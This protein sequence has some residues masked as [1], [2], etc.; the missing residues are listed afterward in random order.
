MKRYFVPNRLFV[1]LMAAAAVILFNPALALAQ[2]ATPGFFT[3]F[4]LEN[5]LGLVIS[6]LTPVV[7]WA[8]K[9]V[10][11]GTIPT[12]L[13]PLLAGT[14]VPWLIDFVAGLTAGSDLSMWQVSLYGLVG[15]ALREILDQL[16]KAPGKVK[17]AAIS[18]LLL[19]GMRPGA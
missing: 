14:V 4:P 19:I 11:W 15:V 9:K 6:V 5:V 3:D 1:F 16:K 17:A 18:F 10:P 8:I 7:V 12:W 2:D 13:L